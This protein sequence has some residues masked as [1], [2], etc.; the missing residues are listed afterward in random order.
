M[1]EPFFQAQN[2]SMSIALPDT[3][4]FH[5]LPPRG[6]GTQQ[7]RGQA[8]QL[9]RSSFLC[10]GTFAWASLSQHLVCDGRPHSITPATSSLQPSGSF[11]KRF[12]VKASNSVLSHL[13]SSS[14]FIRCMLLERNPQ[15]L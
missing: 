5:L 14:S 8:L 10:T 15:L 4:I 7:L 12:D 9:E 6:K 1:Q 13:A 3:G 2:T 11:E